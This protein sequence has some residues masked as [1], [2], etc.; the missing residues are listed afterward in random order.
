MKKLMVGLVMLTSASA[1][2]QTTDPFLNDLLGR[3]NRE[4]AGAQ[5][6]MRHIQRKGQGLRIQCWQGDH[7][8][9]VALR[10]MLRNPNLDEMGS[11]VP[12]PA[13]AYWPF[14]PYGNMQL[15]GQ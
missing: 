15:S 3:A 10:R 1:Y 5:S 13:G 9:C 11:L 2:A 14:D 6:D 4:I 12:R 8:S 7:G